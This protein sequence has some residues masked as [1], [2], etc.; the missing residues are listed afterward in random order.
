MTVGQGSNLGGLCDLGASINLMPT[1]V[2]HKLGLGKPKPTTIM[3]Q[4]ADR[5]VSRPDGIIEDVLV[6]VGS[7]IFPV[8]FVILD[9]EPDPEVPLI[10][11]RPFLATGGELI[12]V[13]AGRLTMRA[14]D[15]VEVFDVYNALKLP[16]VYEELSAI[17]V[18]D[19]EV[20]AKC[21]IAKDPLERVL[22]GQEIE[23]D[24]EAQEFES[25]LNLPNVSMLKKVVEPLDRVLGPAPKLSIEEAPKLEL[26]QLPAHLRYA[27]LGDNSTL[28]VI[29]SSALSDAQVHLALE[30]LKKRKKAMGWQ[31]AD[32]HGISPALCM[33]RIFMEEGHKPMAQPQRRLNPMMKEVVKKEIIKWLDAGII[34][35]ISDS[36]WVSPVQCVPNKGG[37]T[38]V[39]NEKNEL[40]P[41]RTVTG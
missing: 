32:L 4:L 11:G 39:P 22:M 33:H 16:A 6:Q 41:T 8:D 27:F 37:M 23:G 28:P 31:M 30:V 1:S 9:F 7:L 25:V 35:P 15:K 19:A 14:H 36:E 24:A 10:L 13:A 3:L 29:L 21:V 5:S 12:D 2:F 34:Y 40:I 20:A 38:V 18:V 26:K 17:T